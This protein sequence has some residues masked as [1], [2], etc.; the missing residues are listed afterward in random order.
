[1]PSEGAGWGKLAQLVADHILGDIDR[2]K[3]LPIMDG[4]G[5]AN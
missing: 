3:P 4:D 5:V 1:M 2:D